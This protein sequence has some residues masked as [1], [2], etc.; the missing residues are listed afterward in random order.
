MPGLAG[1]ARNSSDCAGNM[2]E[3]RTLCRAQSW[4]GDAAMIVQGLGAIDHHFF[5]TRGV[6]RAMGISLTDAM[7]QGRLTAEG[8]ADMVARCR[9]SDCA[10]N[11]QLWLAHQAAQAKE[12]PRD[13]VNADALN[14]L[15]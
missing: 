8:Y 10:G 15:R 11:C 12:A 4:S 5:L 14:R 7:A 3:P 9:G 2:S 1:R 6:A 13:C